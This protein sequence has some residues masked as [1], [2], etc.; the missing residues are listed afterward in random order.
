MHKRQPH[1]RKNESGNV[2]WFILITIVLIGLLTAILSRSGSNVDQTGNVEQ[3]RIKI[4]KMLR[5]VKGV[6]S[7]VQQMKLRG[8][9]E[10]DLNFDKAAANSTNCTSNDCKVFHVDGGGISYMAPPDGISASATDWVYVGTNNILNVGTTSGDLIIVLRDINDA[11][12]AQINR[13]LD[14]TKGSADNA[15]DFTVFDGSFSETQTIDNSGGHPSGCQ[16]YNN[17]GSN[18][19]IFYYVLVRR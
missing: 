13:M 6:E 1:D 18:E 15:I 7:A 11:S 4:S 16:I 5:Y 14:V 10:S 17:G 3:E 8:I 9:S 12:C 2:L 19:N